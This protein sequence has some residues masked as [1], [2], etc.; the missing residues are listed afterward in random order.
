MFQNKKFTAPFQKYNLY[1]YKVT[2]SKITQISKIEPFPENIE[3]YEGY[4]YF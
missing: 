4:F 2:N 1:P 3:I